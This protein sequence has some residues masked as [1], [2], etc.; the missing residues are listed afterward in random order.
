MKTS[1]VLLL[2][3]PLLAFGSDLSDMDEINESIRAAGIRAQFGGQGYSNQ[4]IE[5][6]IHRGSP[7]PA[8]GLTAEG[9]YKQQKKYDAIQLEIAKIDLAIARRELAKLKAEEAS[10]ESTRKIFEEFRR[11]VAALKTGP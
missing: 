6:Y 1:F 4:Y 9:A 10:V 11:A 2:F 8:V 5:W 3:L 7:A